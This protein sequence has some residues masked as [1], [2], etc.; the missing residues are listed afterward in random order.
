MKSYALTPDERKL[1]LGGPVASSNADYGRAL[2]R[3]IQQLQDRLALESAMKLGHRGRNPLVRGRF[4]VDVEDVGPK[5]QVN[6][7]IWFCY[8]WPYDYCFYFRTST[9]MMLPPL[10]WS[11]PML[12][13]KIRTIVPWK[14]PLPAFI[15]GPHLLSDSPRAKVQRISSCRC[16]RV[17]RGALPIRNWGFKRETTW[18]VCSTTTLRD[19]GQ[20]ETRANMTA[21]CTM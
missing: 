12:R 8:E 3:I 16:M 5:F 14:L 6:K 7:V 18:T 13:K 2:N 11:C 21:R 20:W 4:L 1:A 15:I 17:P 9:T 19:T 10:W